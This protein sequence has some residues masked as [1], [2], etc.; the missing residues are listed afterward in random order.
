MSRD[1]RFALRRLRRAPG[2]TA[3]AVT[4]LALGIGAN[5]A[6]FTVISAVLLRPLP[7]AEP[8]R[9][10]AV[11]EANRTLGSD[12]NVVSPANYLDWAASSSVFSSMA[13]VSDGSVSLSGAGEPVEVPVQRV[14]ASLFPLLG[15]PAELGRTF[16][17]EDDKPGGPNVALLSHRLWNSRYNADPA[18][19]GKPVRLDGSA[20]TVLGVM[21]PE[22][23]S[24][25]R[26]PQPDIWVPMRLDRAVDYRET[27]GRYLHAAARLAPGVT[28]ERAQAEMVT[29][30]SRL[31]VEYPDFNTH[32]T[33]NL[34]PLT[35]QVIG[36][37]RRPLELVGGVV[38]VVLLIACANVA[39]L[40][41]AQ[42]T[43]RRRELA[44]HAAL[45]ASRLDIGRRLLTESLL[46]ALAG[47]ALGVLVAWWCTDVLVTLAASSV[48][49]MHGVRVDAGALAFTLI[50]SLVAGIGFGLLPALHASRRQ[51]YEDL[52]DG[53]RGYSDRGARTR[54]ILVGAQ[55]ACSLVL[56][57][58]AGLLLKSFA[59]LSEVNL[60]FNPDHVLT[61]RVTLGSERYE[62]EALQVR[63]FEE[64]L[65]RVR[66]V[67]GV[68][69]V[70][71]IN[72]LPLSGVGS[73]T[74]MTIQGE[75]PTRP[76]EEPA[77]SVRAVDPDFFAVLEIPLLRGRTIAPTDRAGVPRS[78]VVNQ[79]FVNQYLP[80]RD[81]VGRRILMPWGD[82]LVGTVVGVVGDI[83]DAG[84]DS[85][86]SPT[87]YWALPQFPHSFMTLV[88]RT[89][90]D[91]KG[92]ADGLIRQVRALDPDQ[93]VSDLKLY[94]EWLG[95]MLA[96]RTFS[97][98]L[99]GG[100]AA[101]AVALTSIGLYGATAYGVA[102]RVREFGIRLALGA[103]QRDVL[104]D[105]LRQALIVVG[106][107]IVTGLV[108]A[109]LLSRVLSSLLFQVSPTDPTVFA[110]IA[111]L[112][113]AVGAL[114][115]LLPARRATRVDPLV[116]IRSE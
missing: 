102:R 57:V 88:V 99:L 104:W 1:L 79:R 73:A 67:P 92:V 49:R 25:G 84:V 38:I 14:T 28:V 83:K 115:G 69:A 77:A 37:V 10:V 68:H 13:A 106:A 65:G 56:L 75:P 60:G 5:T 98:S 85:A 52:K 110:A 43:A 36:P 90:D 80:G 42:A 95:M 33:V 23:E 55:V 61:A 27:S 63:F 113:L 93:P 105:V 15:L 22:T 20:Y 45:G 8:D 16:T 46:V 109:V 50:T 41:L 19:V 53:G 18:I 34:V 86:A 48:P 47:G 81:P 101:L 112:L 29:I 39:N 3:A 66:N 30:A 64:L 114:A 74:R 31:T 51:N 82:T 24:I 97:L 87:V 94:D 54:S 44:L 91:P 100:F 70:G 9:V 26:V 59:R 35:E 76:G 78:V 103:S 2:F 111:A 21:P 12:R 58:G 6:I 62:D 17:P 89:A 32:W 7:F 108:G 71:A 116:A 11:W 72:W 4:C 96:R 40:Q 107:G